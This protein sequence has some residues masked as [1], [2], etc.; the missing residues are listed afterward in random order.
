ML[1][2]DPWSKSTIFSKK[3]IFCWKRRPEANSGTLIA[4][5]FFFVFNITGLFSRKIR[6]ILETSGLWIER[7][8]RMGSSR[9]FSWSYFSIFG[10]SGRSIRKFVIR[11]L[12]RVS[13]S[14]S[15]CFFCQPLWWNPKFPTISNIFLK[16]KK[17]NSNSFFYVHRVFL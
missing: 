15:S 8:N 6:S 3:R 13:S 2:I 12:R 11:S 7:Q 10:I 9:S 1:E 14:A 4:H 17:L 16:S 5:T